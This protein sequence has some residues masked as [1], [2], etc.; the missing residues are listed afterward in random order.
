VSELERLVE[1]RQQNF[2][3]WPYL[4]PI[5]VHMLYVNFDGDLITPVG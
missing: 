5:E 1:I 4:V 2:V 3:S